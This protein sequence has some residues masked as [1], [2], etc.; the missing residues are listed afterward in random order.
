MKKTYQKPSINIVLIQHGTALLQ[1]SGKFTDSGPSGGWN[2]GGANSRRG[3][4]DDE[5]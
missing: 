5:E 2:T 1:V 4:W 3:D